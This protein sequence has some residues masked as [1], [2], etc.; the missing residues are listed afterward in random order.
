[1]KND[2]QV[3]LMARIAVSAAISLFFCAVHAQRLPG[4]VRPEHY[5]LA[6]TPD[7]KAATYTGSESIDVTL[8]EPATSITLNAIEITF[9]SAKVTA[10]GKEQTATVSLDNDKQQATLTVPT[11]L[12]A[13]KA[14]IAI[15]F[16]GTLNNELR[17]F[18]LSKT[19][20]RNYAVTQFEALDARR[21]FPCSTNRR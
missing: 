13:G 16:S 21:A 20:K 7:L 11:Q 6:L 18:Y 5:A 2:R 15:E 8:T 19:P 10:G 1:M 3:C 9:K 12:P 14:M 17:G 4:T